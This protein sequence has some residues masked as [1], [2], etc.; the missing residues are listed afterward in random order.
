MSNNK[1]DSTTTITTSS[2]FSDLTTTTTKSSTAPIKLMAKFHL[3]PQNEYVTIPED[4]FIYSGFLREYKKGMLND[5]FCRNVEENL[6]IPLPPIAGKPVY[7]HYIEKLCEYTRHNYGPGSSAKRVPSSVDIRNSNGQK[8]GNSVSN[9]K[10]NNKSRNQDDNAAGRSPEKSSSGTFIADMEAKADAKWS[11]LP[12]WAHGWFSAL[13]KDILISTANVAALLI[14]PTRSIF[15]FACHHNVKAVQIRRGMDN[16][17]AML[18]RPPNE[19]LQKM[20]QEMFKIG[21]I[22]KFQAWQSSSFQRLRKDASYENY[23]KQLL[24][25]NRDII[26][27]KQRELEKANRE[28]QQMAALLEDHKKEIRQLKNNATICIMSDSSI[29]MPPPI[30]R[31]KYPTLNGPSPFS[32]PLSFCDCKTS[33]PIMSD[34]LPSNSNMLPSFCSTLARSNSNNNN[35]NNIL[36]LLTPR[37]A[38]E[39]K[40]LL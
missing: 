37:R 33:T 18:F 4:L 19:M 13:D 5:K 23:Y 6:I 2:T 8:N 16:N 32:T 14:N 28:I 25:K 10:M 27:A 40:L 39:E 15:C 29:M 11:K 36:Q 26:A 7:K 35:S 1:I 38:L 12:D 20:S 9:N 31:Q 30:K 34:Y 21:E 17:A 24:Y 22:V 3:L